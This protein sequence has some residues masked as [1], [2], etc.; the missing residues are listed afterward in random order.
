[1]Y[2]IH[3]GLRENPFNITPD[4]RYIYLSD[5]HEDAL[6]QLLYGIQNKK[7]FLL[8]T[9]E[10]GTG[11][12]M[13]SRTLLERLDGSTET[14]LLLNPYLSES[15]L[16]RAIIDD[17]DI[18][19]ESGSV[20]DM[21]DAINVFLL[22]LKKNGKTAAII[23]D[24]AQN[25]SVKSM[26]LIRML[27]N[28]ETNTEKLLQIVLI[29]QPE[30]V[31]SLH[32][33]SLRQ[34]NQRIAIRAKLGPLSIKDT[35]GYIAHRLSKAGAINGNI[36]TSK[37]AREVFNYTKG[38]PR[39]INSLCD[40]ALLCAYSFDKSAIDHK[41]VSKAATDVLENMF[42]RRGINHYKYAFY[43]LFV[44]FLIALFSPLLIN[45]YFKRDAES[46]KHA[47]ALHIVNKGKA[48][49]ETAAEALQKMIAETASTNSNAV[50][51][52]AA[53]NA[54]E[55]PASSTEASGPSLTGKEAILKTKK[56]YYLT[57]DLSYSLEVS[58]L[59]LLS[60][61][62]EDK[63]AL[64]GIQRLDKPSGDLTYLINKL[65]TYDVNLKSGFRVVERK[66]S[67]YTLRK[68]GIPAIISIR[69]D[70]KVNFFK[71]ALALSYGR[72]KIKILDPQEGVKEIGLRDFKKSYKND[73][74]I[75]YKSPFVSNKPLKMDMVAA[76]VMVLEEG[77]KKVGFFNEAP[78]STFDKQTFEAV[79]KLQIKRGLKPD[80]KVGNETKLALIKEMNKSLLDAGF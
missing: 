53:L 2:K 60:V 77:L 34:L 57:K 50:T 36:F 62:E 71:Y 25:L 66:T 42:M 23:I 59:N 21:V 40:R 75:M 44:I 41:M 78:D 26:E 33:E 76:D 17:F 27:S 74:I 24:E 16:L 29:G 10:V 14:A 65:A 54:T 39:L 64:K 28:L 69:D 35:K 61:W 51:P 45:S 49:A 13:I 4:P 12:T 52:A 37:A 55:N 3:F 8:V 72:R 48:K 30:L 47:K 22:K 7:G 19:C 11:K 58:L 32:G 15:E 79:L 67:L 56:G 9:G 43:T 46:M 1:M 68:L 80:G 31:T 73:A 63:K 6:L 70:S 20:K 18:E 38:Y 5:L